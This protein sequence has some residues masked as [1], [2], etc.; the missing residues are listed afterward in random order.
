MM[1]RVA[2]SI[3][4]FHFSSPSLLLFS[5]WSC[6]KAVHIGLPISILGWELLTR[7]RASFLLSGRLKSQLRPC[8][9]TVRRSK[10]QPALRPSRLAV[11]VTLGGE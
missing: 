1:C 6:E 3:I 5:A 7:H 2:S 8:S 4:N 11:F 9:S 10:A